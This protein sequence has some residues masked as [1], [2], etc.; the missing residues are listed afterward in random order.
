MI[1]TLTLP[2]TDNIRAHVP[3]DYTLEATFTLGKSCTVELTTTNCSSETQRVGGALHS[4]LALSAIDDISLTGFEGS[5]YLDTTVDPEIEAIDNGE[6]TT[7]SSETDR[8]YYENRCEITL[9]DPGWNR[10]ITVTKSGSATTVL[11]NPWKAKATSLGDLPDGG[12]RDFLCV[13][14]ANARPDSRLLA[15][16]EAHTLATTLSVHCSTS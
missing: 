6:E 1:I 11:W 15:P 16:G 12:Y 7:I 5:R 13:E 3:F 2:P 8:I 14:A 4:Y 9:H 10:T